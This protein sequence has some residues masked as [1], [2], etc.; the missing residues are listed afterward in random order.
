MFLSAADDHAP[1]SCA[2]HFFFLMTLTEHARAMLVPTTNQKRAATSSSLS[3][4]EVQEK[5]VLPTKMVVNG[6]G[7][8]P[9]TG[10]SRTLTTAL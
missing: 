10:R 6:L 1:S 4:E 8:G 5:P 3:V 7:P 9:V 2:D